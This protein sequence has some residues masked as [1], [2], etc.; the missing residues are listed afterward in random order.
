MLG[1]RK[2]WYHMSLAIKRKFK[3]CSQFALCARKDQPKYYAITASSLSIVMSNAR[4]GIG[5]LT[6][7]YVSSTRRECQE[8]YLQALLRVL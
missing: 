1:I 2:A 8:E 5:S 7:E 4:R 6:S 3:L